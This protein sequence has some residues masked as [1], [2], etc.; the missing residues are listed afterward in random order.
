MNV[1][2]ADSAVGVDQS[3]PVLNHVP[4]PAGAISIAV[5]RIPADL[6]RAP[7]G[8]ARQAEHVPP[9]PDGAVVAAYG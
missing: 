7:G 9:F 1:K 3:G 6:L 8:G 2:A 4:T 5:A